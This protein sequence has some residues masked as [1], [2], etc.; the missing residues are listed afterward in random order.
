MTFALMKVLFYIRF[1]TD[2]KRKS[3]A[4]LMLPDIVDMG[5]GK[6]QLNKNC[7]KN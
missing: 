5:V 4:I 7:S 1:N 6:V 3:N 2:L